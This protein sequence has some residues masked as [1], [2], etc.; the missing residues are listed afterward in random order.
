MRRGPGYS[1]GESLQGG[2]VE[3]DDR[4]HGKYVQEGAFEKS[5]DGV[6][7]VV[8]TATPVTFDLDDPED[9]IRPALEGTMG[10]LKSAAKHRCVQRD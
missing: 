4:S 10:I 5:L 6:Q 2:S 9:Y 3:K 1:S 8:H 7:G